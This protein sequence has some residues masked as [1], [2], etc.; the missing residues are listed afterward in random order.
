MTTQIKK[1]KALK[2]QAA[3]IIS[4]LTDELLEEKE[5]LEENDDKVMKIGIIEKI[6]MEEIKSEILNKI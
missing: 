3:K 5:K 6:T 1:K 4:E 2:N